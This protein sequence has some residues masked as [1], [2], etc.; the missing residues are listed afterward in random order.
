MP[1]I[2]L[3]HKQDVYKWL[4]KLLFHKTDVKKWLFKFFLHKKDVKQFSER[5]RDKNQ[6]VFARTTEPLVRDAGKRA[7][8]KKDSDYEH[9]EQE[10]WY[11]FRNKEKRPLFYNK[12]LW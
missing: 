6:D 12:E 10:L 8:A 3:L 4:L 7:F 1:F 2:L 9:P 5:S 11:P